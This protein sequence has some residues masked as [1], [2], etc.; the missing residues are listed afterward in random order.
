MEQHVELVVL[1]TE[2]AVDEQDD[3]QIEELLSSFYF[4]NSVTRQ[5]AGEGSRHG[6]HL[7]PIYE[8]QEED[9]IFYD[10]Y[11]T[12]EEELPCSIC[13]SSDED[14]ENDSEVSSQYGPKELPPNITQN[15]SSFWPVIEED[16]EAPDA[17]RITFSAKLSSSRSRSN[18]ILEKDEE[19][20]NNKEWEDRGRSRAVP[21][22][23]EQDGRREWID[24]Q[25]SIYGRE[26]ERSFGKV[27]EF[28]F[29]T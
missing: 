1:Q 18:I 10:L 6:E 13:E 26:Y 8:E 24:D 4:D 28:N 19:N 27:T 7:H 21:A 2:A 20:K 23:L 22:R 25:D 15:P 14:N 29:P 17:E 16:D 5:S 3:A 9:G 11:G 12:V